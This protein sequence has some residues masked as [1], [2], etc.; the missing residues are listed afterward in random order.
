LGAASSLAA[1]WI[2]LAA[3]AYGVNTA[4][5]VGNLFKFAPADITIDQGDTV[6][7]RW[8][9]PDFNHDVNSYPG[10][11]EVYDSHAGINPVVD[12]PPGGTFAHTFT[13]VGTFKYFCQNHSTM[14]GTVTVHEAALP[15]GSDAGGTG[16]ATGQS[17][18]KPKGCISQRN[19]KIRIREP[20]GSSLRS[21]TAT[22]NGRPVA[23]QKKDGRFTAQVDLR[24]FS[25]GTYEVRIKARTKGGRTLT[26]VRRYRTC[27]PKLTDSALPRL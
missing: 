22:L 12:A 10:E 6:T 23:V 7:W 14:Q 15:T 26:G 9:G 18:I 5:D 27:T 11:P 17:Q 4:V 13:H 2:A 21:A 16:G 19:F 25:T 20:H 24:G 3:P 1:A 8:V